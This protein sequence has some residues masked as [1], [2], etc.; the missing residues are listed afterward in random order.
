VYAEA[1]NSP[2]TPL[3][4]LEANPTQTNNNLD[5]DIEHMASAVV[6]P[7][8]GETITSY[9]K[10]ADD[11]VTSLTWIVQFGKEF[12]NLAQGDNKTGTKGTDSIFVM[13]HEEI[14]KIPKDRVVTY[15]RIVVNYRPQKDDPNRV[16]ITAGGNLIQYPGELTT[17]TADLTTAKVLWN[18]VL[19][20]EGAKFCGLDIKNFYLCTPMD[21]YEYMK[22]PIHTF[23][24]HII[25][26]YELDKHAKNGFVYL[27]IRQSIYGLP[28]AGILANKLLRKRLAP[29]GY[30]EV[31]HTPGLWRHAWRPISFTLVVD[32][33]GVKYVGKEHADHLIKTIKKHYTLSEDWEGSLYCGIKL[34]WNYDERYLDISM[35][36]Y[37]ERML[38]KFNHTKPTK[39]QNSPYKP[40]ARKYG[41][42]AQDPVEID[43]TPNIN[44][45][46]IN[47]IQQ[48]VGQALYYARAVEMTILP[49]LSSIAS[50]QTTATENTESQAQHL[51]DYLASNPN[52]VV[53][54]RASA[55]ILNIHSDASYLSESRARSRIGGYFF[56]GDIPK[57]GKPIFINGAI[58]VNCG[59]LK[60]VVTS[61]AEAEL[62]ALFLNAREGKIIRLILSELGHKQPATPIHCDNKTASGIANNTVKRQR[63]R[64]MEMRFF[65]IADQVLLGNFDV[66]WHP[67]QE[68]LGDYFTKHF[69]AK[70]HLEVR[71]WYLHTKD[72]QLLLP[73][74]AAPSTLRGCVGTLPNGYIRQSPLP[75][76]PTVRVRVPRGILAAA[77]A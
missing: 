75:R 3:D 54:F 18:S 47:I 53:R 19:S 11:P 20:T 37:V 4:F 16:R 56:L 45:K 74:A 43:N 38:Q 26:Q 66:Q 1:R 46:R 29:A 50:D 14:L 64:S 68:N 12:G 2:W 23:P 35:P 5:I 44:E 21:R 36:G 7:T 32:D 58:F 72:S 60:I 71:P 34:D 31:A 10:L 76:I 61:A 22:M 65:W 6:H 15:A 17:R 33:F 59:I 40:P 52:A 51:M 69:D 42:A 39:K 73:R 28:Q 41:A 49:G 9:K 70:H 27:E 77:A 13:S 62:G 48:I 55:M 57:D 25:E 24:P 67:G 30:Y 63:S 8:T